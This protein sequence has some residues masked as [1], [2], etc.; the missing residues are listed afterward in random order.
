MDWSKIIDWIKLSP[1]YLLPISIISGLLLFLGPEWSSYFG[2]YQLIS[3]FRSW[4]SLIFIL[5][6]ALIASDLLTRITKYFI[7]KYKNW[8]KYKN[9]SRRLLNLTP[10][11]KN[12]LLWYFVNNSRTQYLSLTNGIVKE[13]EV[14]GIIYRSSNLGEI[15]NWAFN[16]QPWVW[17]YIKNNWRKIFSDE[18]I[19]YFNK[20]K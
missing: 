3:K 16:I 6:I 4:I 14:F 1:K 19:E 2:L 7:K 17:I 18:D 8:Y 11:E 12:I 5:S 20:N 13:L 15:D 10:E 9:T